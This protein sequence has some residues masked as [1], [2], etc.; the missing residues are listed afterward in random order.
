MQKQYPVVHMQEETFPSVSTLLSEISEEGYS[1]FDIE[2]VVKQIKI[3]STLNKAE[4]AQLLLI[5]GGT[6]SKYAQ[7]TLARALFNGELLQKNLS[8]S[9]SLIHDLATNENYPEAICDLAQFYENGIG[10]KK[11]TKRAQE[12]YKKAMDLGIHRASGHYKRMIKKDKGLLSIF[13]R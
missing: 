2:D 12:L 13:K 4:A 8:D 6:E 7:F 10:T 11:D 5:V 1:E 3:L 9:F